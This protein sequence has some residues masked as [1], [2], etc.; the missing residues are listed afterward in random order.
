MSESI[1]DTLMGIRWGGLLPEL[2]KTPES[3]LAAEIA[4]WVRSPDAPFP[5]PDRPRLGFCRRYIHRNPELDLGR[6]D[7]LLAALFA[8]RTPQMLRP[9]RLPVCW[10]PFLCQVVRSGSGAEGPSGGYSP[11]RPNCRQESV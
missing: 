5:R 1:D 7:K 6:V 9:G 4:S 11:S 3:R 10:V 2:S 8:L